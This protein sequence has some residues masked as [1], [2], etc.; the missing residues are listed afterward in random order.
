SDC[1][2]GLLAKQDEAAA[3]ALYDSQQLALR[4]FREITQALALD[5]SQIE[6]PA[7]LY[8]RSKA[9]L[10]A[11]EAEKVA[12]RKLGI[13]FQD[14]VIPFEGGVG[15]GVPDQIGFNAAQYVQGLAGYL[16]K[17]GVRIYEHSQV[18]DRLEDQ[19]GMQRILANGQWYITAKHVIIASGYPAIDDGARF[20]F[21][22]V[23]SRS[24]CLAYPVD[25]IQPGMYIT[26]GEPIHSVRYA[27]GDTN[28]LVIAGESYRVG[29]EADTKKRQADLKDFARSEFSVDEPAY[30]WSAQDYRTADR[31]PLIG[32]LTDQAKHRH[33][34]VATGFRKW[35]L[36]FAIFSGVYLK[37]L[38]QGG[39]E[40]QVFKPSR[41]S[42]LK[43][44]IDQGRDKAAML[45]KG[46]IHPPKV[47]ESPDMGPGTGGIVEAADEKIGLYVEAQGKRHLVKP[48]CTHMGCPLHWN[49][50]EESYDC[51]CHGSR[52][53]KEGF[54]IEGP[55]RR[56]LE[57]LSENQLETDQ[58]E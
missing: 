54:L 52:F 14:V 35:G 37:E 33:V 25:K 27:P 5:C 56:D 6:T 29:F 57:R 18:E 55:A 22:L 10:N 21:R 19:D 50:L 15:I 32:R 12:Y 24:H 46:L 31:L 53:T 45:A 4:R 48:V 40:N 38:I 11:L 43:T 20:D 30:A 13:P 51:A 28:H 1:Y 23:P 58:A 2:A 44:V 17:K 26:Q 42:L 36:G 16:K 41:E 8:G 39:E 34:Y 7:I 49:E 47:A 9:E 3:M